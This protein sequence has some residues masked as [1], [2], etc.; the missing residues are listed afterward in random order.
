MELGFG[1]IFWL[2]CFAAGLGMMTA[3]C[4]L[5][6]FTLGAFV[7][8]RTRRDSSEPFFRRP[9]PKH[10]SASQAG[11]AFEPGE[12]EGRA[13]GSVSQYGTP[14]DEDIPMGADVNRTLY[15][16]PD[17]RNQFMSDFQMTSSQYK[18]SAEPGSGQGEEDKI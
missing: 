17:R 6:S 10:G 11:D 16:D 7:V 5:V 15:G 2:F 12:N 8:Y 14:E 9:E 18:E 13:S 4:I 1:E 3:V